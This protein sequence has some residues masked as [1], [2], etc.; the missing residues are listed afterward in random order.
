[1][2]QFVIPAFSLKSNQQFIRE[3]NEMI[4]RGELPANLEERLAFY[5]RQGDILR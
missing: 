1:M 3:Q 4:A 5:K 2:N